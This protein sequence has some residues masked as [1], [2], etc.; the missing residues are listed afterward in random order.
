MKRSVRST[1][2][3]RDLVSLTIWFPLT[4]LAEDRCFVCGGQPTGNVVYIVE[5][6]V[7]HQKVEVCEK[8]QQIYSLC[9]VCGLPA[10]TNAP[11]YLALEDGR[12]ICRRDAKTAVVQEQQVL[13]TFD[14]VRDGL[15]RMFSRFAGF[16]STNITVAMVDRVNLLKLFKLA[17]NDY[18]CP[19]VLGY[20]ESKT[21]QNAIQHNIS[22]MSGL[23]LSWLR[24]VCAHELTHA[25]VCEN[26]DAKRKE[27]LDRDAEE[28]FCEL[29]AYL[30]AGAQGD[31][32]EQK[33][34][35]RNTYTRGQIDLFVAA[36]TTYGFNDVLDWIR[37]GVDGRLS[38]SEP[39]RIRQVQL[40]QRQAAVMPSYSF[41]PRDPGPA[42][43]NLVLKAVFWDPKRPLALIN[44]HTFAI[45]EEAKVRLGASNVL[46]RCLGITPNSARVQVSGSTEEQQLVLRQK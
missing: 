24:A 9:F 14:Q 16:P 45:T 41:V 42:P 10:S 7:A 26:V 38:V 44:E 4:L 12:V 33:E 15:D 37:Y 34:I 21:N 13:S 40:P 22:L 5:D 29:V 8:C 23:P 36:E 3:F 32:T 11:G 19:N 39:G 2:L 17:G 18:H 28:G 27:T 43:T 1:Q 30:L 6:K 35:L 25:W 31:Q 46:V 20:T